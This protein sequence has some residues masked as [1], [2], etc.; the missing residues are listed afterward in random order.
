MRP[1][2][3][4]DKPEEPDG[5]DSLE[6]LAL[7]R[8]ELKVE[9]AAEVEAVEVEA[10]VVAEVRRRRQIQGRPCLWGS[11]PSLRVLC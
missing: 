7:Q 5:P 10:V 8:E 9:A 11:G 6:R 3:L 2:L 4:E 1:G